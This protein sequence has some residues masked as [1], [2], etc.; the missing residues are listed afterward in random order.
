MKKA[1]GQPEV[2]IES[3]AYQGKKTTAVLVDENTGGTAAGRKGFYGLDVAGKSKALFLIDVSGSMASASS[4]FPGKTRLDVLKMELKKSLFGGQ[5]L[6][7]KSFSRSGG[8][9]IIAF[10]STTSCF[11]AASNK[12]CHVMS[13]IWSAQL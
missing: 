9:I 3:F 7:E 13:P 2:G 11:P 12:L 6:S 1:T 5:E 4:E 8:F 10:S